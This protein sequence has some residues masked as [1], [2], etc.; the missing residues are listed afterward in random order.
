MRSYLCLVCL[1][2]VFAAC[3]KDKGLAPIDW[4]AELKN[5]VWT[6][7]IQYTQG[8]ILVPQYCSIEFGDDNYIKV[9]GA[10]QVHYGTW[11]IVDSSIT[12]D[13]GGITKTAIVGKQRWTQ[14]Q[15]SAASPF[16]FHSVVR[17]AAVIPDSL[18][19]TVWNGTFVGSSLKLEFLAGKR[20]NLTHANVNGGIQVNVAYTQ[21]GSGISFASV[22]NGIAA[23]VSYFGCFTNETRTAFSGI[24]HRTANSFV[25]PWTVAK[26]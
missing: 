4:S 21:N 3:K 12:L 5:T 15:S 8:T 10:L 13:F 14:F 16:N 18:A 7:E 24:G 20:L 22:Y 26:Q 9:V 17:S 23:G 2:L 6:G 1:V 11:S 25:H 19:G